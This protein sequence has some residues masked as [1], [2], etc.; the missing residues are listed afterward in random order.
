MDL[1]CVLVGSDQ[2]EKIF[3]FGKIRIVFWKQKQ[4]PILKGPICNVFS[5]IVASRWHYYRSNWK[6][7][8]IFY[9]GPSTRKNGK[10]KFWERA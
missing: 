6:L 4:F 5:V 10:V 8:L 3:K 7:F 1:F 2:S 9:V